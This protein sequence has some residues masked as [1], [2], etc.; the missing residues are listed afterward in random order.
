MTAN[1]VAALSTIIGIVAVSLTSRFRIGYLISPFSVSILMLVAIFGVRPLVID[2]SAGPRLYQYATND[3][4]AEATIVGLIAILSVICGYCLVRNSRSPGP[5]VNEAQRSKKHLAERMSRIPVGAMFYGCSA[6]VLLWVALMAFRGGGF[7]ALIGMAGGRSSASSRIVENLPLIIY[8]LPAAS[9]LTAA[10][11]RLVRERE[12]MHLAARE[13]IVYWTVVIISLFPPLMLGNRRFILPCVVAAVIAANV[14]QKR[15]NARIK[16]H[17]LLLAALAF[18]LLAIV[19]FI[20]SSGSRNQGDS[21]LEALI[22]FIQTEGLRGVLTNFF[23]SYDTEMLDY[24]AYVAPRLGTDVPYGL[25]RGTIEDIFLAA[26]PTRISGTASW[27]NEILIELFGQPCGAGICPVP[28]FA[29][30]AFF[31]F[32]YV[33]VVAIGVVVGAASKLFESAVFRAK[34]FGLI[35]VLILGALPATAIRGNYPS[36]LWIAVN[37]LVTACVLVWI[38]I[39]VSGRSKPSSK[40]VSRPA[41]ITREIDQ[42]SYT[43][44]KP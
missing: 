15:W 11:W 35:A 40:P 37:I 28:S 22:S 27:S 3:G 17:Q 30:T 18:M 23:T 39:Q 26:I 42:R 29:G 2:Y 41:A 44:R 1:L 6:F 8:C 20:R 7:D 33:G 24:I 34:G 38:L 21:L 25:G 9:A 13:K 43:L 4:V 31:D 14:N 5:N 12:G 10:S 16:L 19:P 32:S 36:Q